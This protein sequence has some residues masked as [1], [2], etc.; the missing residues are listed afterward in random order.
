MKRFLFLILVLSS[1][2]MF[3]QS[4]PIKVTLPTSETVTTAFSSPGG[5][6]W[7]TGLKFNTLLSSG[8]DS[9]YF[10]VSN[11]ISGDSYDTLKYEGET[12]WVV[13][14]STT[15]SINLNVN[16]LIGWE[17]FKI[18]FDIPYAIESNYYFYA[19]FYKP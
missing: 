8:Q 2:S 3:A 6:Y 17:K 14:E 13:L 1:I 5:G 7:L 18:G 19:Q 11:G 15:E 10:L 9:L 12:Y 4:K 16:A